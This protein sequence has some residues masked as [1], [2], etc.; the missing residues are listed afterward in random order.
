MCCTRHLEW[1]KDVSTLSGEEERRGRHELVHLPYRSWYKVCVEGRGRE[2]APRQ[3]GGGV[4]LA[5]DP[6]GPRAP[7]GGRRRGGHDHLGREGAEHAHDNIIIGTFRQELERARCE[8]GARVHDGG[9]VRAGARGEQSTRTM[10]NIISDV[11]GARAA[12]GGGNDGRA[13]PSRREPEQRSHRTSGRL[14]GRPVASAA[15]GS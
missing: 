7:V 4:E 8:E 9:G 14:C 11:G 10:K 6:N 2:M 15:G 5:Q 13:Q 12:A 3:G 1:L